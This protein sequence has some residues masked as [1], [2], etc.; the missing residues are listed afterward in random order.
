[1][2]TSADTIKGNGQAMKPEAE[3][4][5]SWR[6]LFGDVVTYTKWVLD[7]SKAGETHSQY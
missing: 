7:G 2:G 4:I 1:M 3:T 5:D 6:K